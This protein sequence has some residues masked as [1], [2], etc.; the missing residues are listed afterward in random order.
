MALYRASDTDRCRVFKGGFASLLLRMMPM[1]NVFHR[2][3]LQIKFI[4]RFWRTYVKPLS[5]ILSAITASSRRS[6]VFLGEKPEK[7]T[8]YWALAAIEARPGKCRQVGGSNLEVALYCIGRPAS[9]A[10]RDAIEPEILLF[11]PYSR[12][13]S[14]FFA[15]P[16]KHFH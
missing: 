3:R 12:Q 10:L 14:C 7:K 15:P 11:G 4:L 8:L 6:N 9:E 16:S 1:V 5:V 13:F 2:I